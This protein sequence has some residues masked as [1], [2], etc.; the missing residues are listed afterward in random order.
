[1]MDEYVDSTMQDN[2]EELRDEVVGHKIVHA[3]RTKVPSR[4]SGEEEVFQITLDNG[5]KVI[6]RDTDDCC[7]YTELEA[8]LFHADQV[9]NIVTSVEGQDDYSKWFVLAD[10]SKVLELTVG[11][12]EGSGYYGYGFSIEV[13]DAPDLPVV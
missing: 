3:G 7:A 1:M 9:D 6:L 10:M 5:K 4:W 11:W 8:F 13:Q 2:L 12:S